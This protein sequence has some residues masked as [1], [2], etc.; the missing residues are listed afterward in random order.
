MRTGR[1]G[2]KLESFI[3]EP[4]AAVCGE[5]V[6]QVL[7]MIAGESAAARE[8]SLYLAQRP[9]EVVRTLEK[10][11]CQPANAAKILSL[12]TTH[13]VPKAG[14]IEKTLAR[15]NDLQP[16]SYEGMLAVEGV[17]PA[18]IRAFALVSEVVYN[19]KASRKDPVRYSFAHGGK[20]GHPFP[21]NRQDYDHSIELL[22][23][24]LRRAKTG[25]MENIK[26]LKRLSTLSSR[27]DLQKGPKFE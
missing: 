10:I 24:A 16:S 7:N 3:Q 20:D 1:L 6:A 27:I 23:N 5:P 13:P 12:P 25:D 9:D 14:R 19:A 17:G 4:H 26:A 18:T 22:E 15:L 8:T 11:A 21:V 2:D